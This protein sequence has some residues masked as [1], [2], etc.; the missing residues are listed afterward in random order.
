[1]LR[2]VQQS[3]GRS[4][5]AQTAAPLLRRRSATSIAP[6]G[7]EVAGIPLDHVPYFLPDLRR[8]A[9]IGGSMVVLLIGASFLL[10]H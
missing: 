7:S 1:M 2:A 5:G 8:L 3:L 10:F 6:L 4:M 9:I